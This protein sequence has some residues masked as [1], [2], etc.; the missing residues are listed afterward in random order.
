V[1]RGNPELHYN[2]IEHPL[3]EV[4]QKTAADLNLSVGIWL[5][6]YSKEDKKQ[7]LT[8]LD[9]FDS[10]MFDVSVYIVTNDLENGVKN[11]KDDPLEF[12][13]CSLEETK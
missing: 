10:D 2:V 7:T 5:D 3:N 4:G 8:N 1:T 13:L 11:E 12:K 6:T 9:L